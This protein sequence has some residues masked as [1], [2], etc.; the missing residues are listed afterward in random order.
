MKPTSDRLLDHE[1]DG[2]REYD[3]PTPGWWHAI[4]LASIVFSIGYFAFWEFSPEAPTPASILEVKQT[5]EYQQL[6]G[7]IGDLEGD[8]ATVRRMMRDDKMM[9]VARS[10]FEANCVACHAKDG[11]G[12]N[13][14]NLTDNHYKNV[15]GIGDI[16][17][18]INKGANSGAMPAWEN[19]LGKNERVLLAAFTASLRGTKPAN[20]KGPE[21]TEIAPWDESAGD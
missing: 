20:P 12:S 19:R 10:M 11:G 16:F 15:K 17:G 18:V 2:I 6:F 4:F 13:G 3:N 9:Q 14:V 7:E 1:Y 8:E 21:G 5:R